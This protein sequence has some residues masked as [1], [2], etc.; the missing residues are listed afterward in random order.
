MTLPEFTYKL[1]VIDA[2]HG[3]AAWD[4]GAGSGIRDDLLLDAVTRYIR[5]LDGKQYQRLR[6]ESARAYLTDEMIEQ[7]HGMDT[8]IYVDM[9]IDR[10]RCGEGDDE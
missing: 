9:W 5:G 1:S 7:G 8:A 10:V 6:A 2:I 3:L 4:D